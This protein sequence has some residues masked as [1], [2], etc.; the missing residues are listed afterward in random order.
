[1]PDRILAAA[2]QRH[3]IQN[4][5]NVRASVFEAYLGALHEEAGPGALEQ[6]IRGI[7]LPLV[8]KLVDALRDMQTTSSIS[9]SSAVPLAS[10]NCVGLLGEWAVAR[11]SHGRAVTY[12]PPEREGCDHA[13]LWFVT[14]S[15]KSKP[16]ALYPTE[17]F[18]GEGSTVAAAKQE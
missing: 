18:T 13:P 11:G 5:A 8:P 9:L 1:M 17:L 4:N 3:T 2:A 7:Y 16:G 6:F 12:L 10:A 14:C 15:V